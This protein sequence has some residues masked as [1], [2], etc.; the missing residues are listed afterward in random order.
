MHEV[1]RFDCDRGSVWSLCRSDNEPNTIMLQWEFD[2]VWHNR[3]IVKFTGLLGYDQIDIVRLLKQHSSYLPHPSPVATHIQMQFKIQPFLIMQLAWTSTTAV[4][5]LVVYRH[6]DIMLFQTVRIGDRSS[7]ADNLWLQLLRLDQIKGQIV[8]H[9]KHGDQQALVFDSGSGLRLS[10]IKESIL[11]ILS[12]A[13]TMLAAPQGECA[14]VE[15]EP[16]IKRSL[17]REMGITDQLWMLLK[18]RFCFLC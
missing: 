9:K 5:S 10:T 11:K 2:E 3:G 8:E 13:T 14:P 18:R 12:D 17:E 1:N 6:A 15:L 4:P 7:A 16:V